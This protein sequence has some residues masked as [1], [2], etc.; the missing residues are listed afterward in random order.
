MAKG[1]NMQPE[2]AIWRM[3]NSKQKRRTYHHDT[4]QN[5]SSA[6]LLFQYI[7]YLYRTL[8][9]LYVQDMERA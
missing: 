8:R 3:K 6:L 1:R 9:T 2:T 4:T 5:S 7:S